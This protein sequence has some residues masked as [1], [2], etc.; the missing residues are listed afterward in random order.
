MRPLN[1]IY[2]EKRQ[3]VAD[4]NKTMTVDGNIKSLTY[5]RDFVSGEEIMLIRDGAATPF[6]I[7]VT[8][9]S[10]K[11]ILTE[12]SKFQLG[13]KPTGLIENRRAKVE[14]AKMFEGMV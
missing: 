8:G 7:N 3:F 14:F 12:A 6:Y 2:N 11:A 1:E 5:A 9:N 10:L 13:L 4:L